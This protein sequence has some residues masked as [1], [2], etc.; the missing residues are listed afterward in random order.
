MSLGASHKKGRADFEIDAF[1][2][3]SLHVA[4]LG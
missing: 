3:V 1:K 4:L 2:S